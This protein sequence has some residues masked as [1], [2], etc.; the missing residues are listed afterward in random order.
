MLATPLYTALATLFK[1]LRNIADVITMV[2]SPLMSCFRVA[3]SVLH[4][5]AQPFSAFLNAVRQMYGRVSVAFGFLWGVVSQ[6]PIMRLVVDRLQGM[7]IQ[8][9]WNELCHSNLDPLKAQVALIQNILMRSFKQVFYGMKFVMQRISYMSV[10][11]RRERDYAREETALD[12]SSPPVNSA[13]DTVAEN[14]VS[15]NSD[16]KK[17]E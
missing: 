15:S 5:L 10:F 6:S 4:P 3:L 7:G 17:K 16:K 2:T 14:S 12:A 11:I 9:V 8:N 1:P 13:I